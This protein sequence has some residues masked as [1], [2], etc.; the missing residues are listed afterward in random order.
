RVY[1][2]PTAG[3]ASPQTKKPEL[4]T[5]VLLTCIHSNSATKFS[6]CRSVRRKPYGSPEVTISPFLTK[7]VPGAVLTR[8]QPVKS[9]PLKNGTNSVFLWSPAIAVMAMT[10]NAGAMNSIRDMAGALFLCDRFVEVE[11]HASHDRPGGQL[12][13]GHVRGQI[14][15]VSRVG[16]SDFPRIHA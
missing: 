5:S 1:G 3:N 10:S 14:R 9:R 7:N 2:V 8:A 11:Q 12:R 6:Y 4:P 16:G 13:R 15:R